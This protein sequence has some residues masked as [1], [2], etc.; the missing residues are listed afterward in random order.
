[1]AEPEWQFQSLT[2]NNY[3]VLVHN[4]ENN[5]KNSDNFQHFVWKGSNFDIS[6][7]CSICKK[8][9][10][11]ELITQALLLNTWGI[12]KYLGLNGG[13]KMRAKILWKFILDIIAISLHQEAYI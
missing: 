8:R 9:P 12:S 13:L 7:H 4:C 11:E 5:K 2:Y 10:S 1:M 3:L 6:P